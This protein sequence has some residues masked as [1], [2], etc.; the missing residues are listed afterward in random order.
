MKSKLGQ[1]FLNNKKIAELEVENAD[2]KQNDVVLEIGP[3]KGILTTIL[4]K[5][6]KRVIAIEIDKKLI[7]D[8]QKTLPDNVI[9]IN[10]DVLKTDFKKLPK[11]NKIVS[12]LPFQISSPVTFKILE[13][14]F[15]V[16]ILIYQKEFADRMVADFGTKNYSR[17]SVN[18]YYRAFCEMIQKVPKT[19]FSPQPKVDSCM[20]KLIPR[21]EPPFEVYDEK[22]FF[23]LTRDLFNHRRKKISTIIRLK[24]PDINYEKIPFLDNRV[25]E[26][27]PREISILSNKVF[28]LSNK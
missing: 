24:Y 21:D 13:Y 1:N 15:D 14:P 8:L 6:A 18:V 5:K 7:G 2:I 23:K 9:L 3:G 22:L 11:F 20:L 19:C 26:L 10:Q 12:N 27:T 4:S 16:A 28:T 25:E 17:L